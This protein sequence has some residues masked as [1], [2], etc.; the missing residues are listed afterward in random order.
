MG[1]V[2]IS[3]SRHDTV[4]VERLEADLNASG[5]QTWR[6]TQ[7]IVGGEEWYNAIIEGIQNA[8]TLLQIVTVH[9]NHSRWVK[10]EALFADQQGVPI[11]PILPTS[12]KMPFH[13]IEK[14]PINCDDD[15][16]ADSLNELIVTLNAI[17]QKIASSP[18]S[19]TDNHNRQ[20]ELQYLQFLLA[21]TRAD[22]QSALYVGLA[23]TPESTTT[24]RRSLIPHPRR[25]KLDRLGLET[26]HDDHFD[27]PGEPVPDARIPLR[28]MQ[29]V[30]LLGEPGSGK[31][32]T[33]L[34]L[35]IELAREAMNDPQAPLPV[36]V[37]LR[38][39]Q[40]D[41]SFT[42]FVQSQLGILEGHFTRLVGEGRF[43]YLCDALNE[44]PRH[45]PSG[46]SLIDDVRGFLFDHNHWI[47]SC[48]IRDYQE[49]LRTLPDV[50]KIRL[51]PLTL[52]RILEVI[53][54][55][56]YDEPN[57]A[58]KL[59]NELTG[60]DYLLTVWKAYADAGH[61]NDFW[62]RTWHPDVKGE[63]TRIWRSWRAMHH[64]E[65][66]MMR[67]CRNPYMLYLVCEIFDLTGS[68]P[69]NRGA[70]FATFVDDLLA[71]EESLSLESGLAWIDTPTIRNALADLAFEIQQQGAGTQIPYSHAIQILSDYDYDAELL[72]RI[73][74]SASIL[75]VGDTVR[76][77]HQLLQEYFASE[78]MG[79]VMDDGQPAAQF[80]DSDTWWEQKGWEET[81]II[82]AG[83]R[84]DSI[85]VAAWIAPANPELAYQTLLESGVQLN[86][87]DLDSQLRH[88]II[89][90]AYDKSSEA[91]PIGRAAAMRVLG[92]LDA[93]K[94]DGLGLLGNQ[95]PDIKWCP[96]PAGSFFMGG[97]PDAYIPWDGARIDIN[98]DY[99]L[100]K[101]PITYAQYEAFVADNGYENRQNWSESGWAWRENWTHSRSHWHDP[102]FH[103]SNHPVVGI[104][105][106]EAVAFSKW[107][108]EK[109]QSG[110]L[111]F[112]AQNQPFECRL[113]SESEWE[114][115]AR[116]D[117]RRKF[118]FGDQF[119]P[120]L[121]NTLETGIARTC[122]V[123]LFEFTDTHS[124][125]QDM[126]GNVW[127]WCI[128]AWKPNYQY[129]ENNDAEHN[130]PAMLRGGSWLDSA[131]DSRC[132]TR[133]YRSSR[134]RSDYI[135]FRVGIFPC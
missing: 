13:L 1:H 104:T 78:V 32:T 121:C 109:F 130:A 96:V 126:S 29:H 88:S 116:G 87:D 3:Y 105:W 80:W 90:S 21:E 49:D 28:Q 91:N 79:H 15:H 81:A 9:S 22:L 65:R 133:Y 11:I 93:D 95:L 12:T 27:Q 122:A 89:Q 57:R 44:M 94:R 16:Y 68:L 45:D 64:D 128:S 4:F 23:A 35:T 59:W 112:P 7:S 6:D 124:N 38:H 131:D 31:T 48:R 102:K 77:T 62:N 123:G 92:Y 72:L 58:T 115:A 18:T 100:S 113:P 52:P 75:I 71:R 30:L 135:G 103:I 134:R 47:V 46:N 2:F 14:Q 5:I 41:Q 114:K 55:R 129:P 110:L 33:L 99:W 56:F 101:Y 36:F 107:L 51:Q 61:S 85:T 25:P 37:P 86:L 83:V 20:R 127:E 42:E 117:D 70:L 111:N 106:Y 53:Q 60:N 98:Y 8:Y 76:F 50:G 24:D 119:A 132:A 73:A 108:N 19:S 118:A 74:S 10:R 120:D 43:I 97:D 84:G 34:Q 17:P 125:I 82:L 26:I 69:A 39:F 54:R 40:G 63:H 66:Q 67:L